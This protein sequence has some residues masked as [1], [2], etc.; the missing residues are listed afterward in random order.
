MILSRNR[1]FKKEPPSRDA[2]LFIFVCEGEKREVQY[3]NYFADL[4]ARFAVVTLPPE[5]GKDHS[6]SGL[7]DRVDA[8]LSGSDAQLIEPITIAES[9][10]IWYIIDTDDWGEKIEELATKI[11]QHKLVSQMAV[12]QSNPCFE[13]WL[14][15]HFLPEPQ[16]FANFE[17]ATAWKQHLIKIQPGNFSA[18]KHP[19]LIRDAIDAAS[20]HY[21]QRDDGQPAVGSTQVFRPATTIYEALAHKLDSTRNKSF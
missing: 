20:T 5:A 9:D 15:Y 12:A 18:L 1:A 10:Q 8:Y 13:V 11:K 6:P 7:V 19:I 4:D 14:C 17:T 2:R 21:E 16:Y 3:F